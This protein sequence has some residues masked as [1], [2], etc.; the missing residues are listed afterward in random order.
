MKNPEQTS[1]FLETILDHTHM[2]VAYMDPQSNFIKVNKAYAEADEREPS[3]FP[4]KNH[5]DLYP[6]AEN[7]K[8]FQKVIKTGKSYIARGKAFEYAEH[9]ER[10]TSYWDWSLIPIKKADGSVSALVLTLSDVTE[11]VLSETEIVKAKRQWERTF[12][13]VPDL[14]MILDNHHK[15]LRANKA[16]ADKLGKNPKDLV[17]LS[18]YEIVHDSKEPPKFCPHARLLKDGKEHSS[19]VHEERLGG[20]FLIT[21]SP[22]HDSDGSILGSVHV[23]RDITE[24]KKLENKLK[25]AHEE[26]EHK[27]KESTKELLIANEQ[28]R[29]E[30]QERNRIE[31]DLSE[32]ETRYRTVADFTFD[33]E[34]WQG[35]DEK[36]IYVSPS[37]ERIT[38]YKA[39]E[40]IND[41]D[42]LV[43]VIIDEDRA[44]WYKHHKDIHKKTA[45]EF[46]FRIFTK[47]REERWIEHVCLPII[48]KKGKFL[49][50]RASQRDITVRKNIEK[51]IDERLR[52]ERLLSETSAT[53]AN[54]PASY[55]EEEVERG[56]KKIVEFLGV[57]RG[58]VFE[59][60]ADRK[61]LDS[62]NSY[63][64][65]GLIAYTGDTTEH[66]F[67][68]IFKTLLEG[69]TIIWQHGKEVMGDQL[70]KE[71]P[72]LKALGIKSKISIPIA[73]G[74]TLRAV[75]SLS[76]SKH[77]IDW[78]DER[79]DRIR[80]I[81]EIFANA[82]E[83]KK[84][85]TD[86]QQL[87][88]DL[89]HVS[90][91]N[92]LSVLTGALAH[93]INQPLAAIMSNAQTAQRFLDAQKFDSEQLMEILTD[94]TADT[95]RASDVIQK[96]RA[97]M[98]KK[99]I[100]KTAIDLNEVIKE[101][102]SLTTRDADDKNISIDLILDPGL[103]FVLSDRVQLQQ[104]ILNLLINAFDAMIYQAPDRRRL[105]IRTDM[106]DKN[107]IQVAVQDEG[108]GIEEGKLEQIF[109][110][111]NTSKSGGMGL[112]LSI[113][114]SIIET[115][116]GRIW[117]ENKPGHGSI[118]YFTLPIH[119]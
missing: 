95:S 115:Y 51:E 16:M 59:F 8:I 20:D 24:Q 19:E 38:G 22:L 106:F 72:S 73:V 76:S 11:R 104:V 47:A 50:R 18:C 46:Q 17:G 60:S 43:K 88:R 58:T 54:L 112:G 2:L 40:F 25:K 9:P 71:K 82:L 70:P 29:N 78:S 26:L 64:V 61:S 117:A 28:L 97:M 89:A 7:E 48:D 57:D 14:I 114:Q 107:N 63:A 79:V 53:F 116:G 113:N 85:E 69:K 45:D 99:D 84:A 108:M 35:A 80:L 52:F 49:G 118:F 4:G 31:K 93:E 13:A 68:W 39:E 30:I 12:D 6:N 33:W 62:V 27:V 110:P 42:L 32:A 55:V 105:I 15:I 101:V 102:V 44:L 119:E 98:K 65:P 74:G 21:V 1:Q 5:F 56:L 96:L 86:A 75:I 90:R 23:A 37:C 103:P 77:D 36:L 91:L 109:Q 66:A 3:F 100:E 10:G 67:P 34:Y 92:T 111:F 41:P 81:G 83:R 87:R 94:I